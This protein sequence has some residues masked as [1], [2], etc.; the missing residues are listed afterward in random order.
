MMLHK[1]RALGKGWRAESIAHHDWKQAHPLDLSDEGLL[2][3]LE[4]RQGAVEKLVLVS[5]K[6]GKKKKK[7]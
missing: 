6:A 1:S 2:S 4:D 7:G 3:D 5:E